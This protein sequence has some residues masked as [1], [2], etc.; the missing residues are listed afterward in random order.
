MNTF[1][2]T[3]VTIGILVVFFLIFGALTYNEVS[4][5][6][7]LILFLGLIAGIRSIWKKA[8]SST[9]IAKKDKHELDKSE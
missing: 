1:S 3:I 4:P 7:S 2:K 5:L 8:P 6:I 9:E